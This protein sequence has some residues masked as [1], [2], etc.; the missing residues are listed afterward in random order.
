MRLPSSLTTGI[1]ATDYIDK[2]KPFVTQRFMSSL[3]VNS[4]WAGTGIN[5]VIGTITWAAVAKYF[6]EAA[7]GE[8]YVVL[9][10]NWFEKVSKLSPSESMRRSSTTS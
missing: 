9:S 3:A 5:P 4:A 2:V 1:F 6:C 8:L 10:P 7:N